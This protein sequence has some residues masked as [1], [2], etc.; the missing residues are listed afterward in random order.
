M[1]R[2]GVLDLARPEV[3]ALAALRVAADLDPARREQTALV[4][5]GPVA[6]EGTTTLSSSYALSVAAAGRRVLLIDADL[7]TAALTERFGWSRDPGLTDVLTG[8]ADRG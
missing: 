1:A 5:V 8:E 2:T 3:P 4:F 6:G 7:H